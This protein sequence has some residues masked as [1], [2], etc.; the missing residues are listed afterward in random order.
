MVAI[1]KMET[2]LLEQIQ[3]PVVMAP[4]NDG[5]CRMLEI[6][7]TAGQ[8]AWEIPEDASVRVYYCK[9]DGTG[10]SYD[11]LEDGSR[12]WTAQGNVITVAL[13]PQMLSVAGN[14]AAK[15]EFQQEE[16]V[17][18]TF[19]FWI[20]VQADC[21]DGAVESEDYVNWASWTAEKLE[22]ML[23]GAKASGAFD[24]E[25]GEPGYTPVRG[26]DYWTAADLAQMAGD[27]SQEVADQLADRTQLMPEYADNQE[28]CTDT[29]KLYVLPDGYI[30]A[31][32]Y[33]EEIL[34]AYTNL[35]GEVRTDTRLNSSGVAKTLTGAVTTD[36]IPVSQGQIVRVRGFDP[37]ALVSGNYPYIC[38]YT[39]ADESAVVSS[40]IYIRGDW[41][42]TWIADGDGYRYEAF[43]YASTE[44]Q[45]ALASSI[46][47][48]RICG[49]A[50]DGA[51]II[52][53]V[54]EEIAE[55]VEGSYSWTNTGH[56]FVAA[57]YEDRIIALEE[58]VEKI[59]EAKVWTG[60]KW[61]AVGD[62]LTYD[63]YV[64]TSAYYHDHIA[65]ETGITVVNMGQGG[66]GYKRTFDT[67]EG[68]AF[69]QRI[70]NVPTDADVITIF[71]SGNDLSTTWE[72]YGLGEATDTGTD[73]I[74]GCINTTLDNLFSVFP[75][76]NVGIIT[77]TPWKAFYPSATEADGKPYRMT[78]L[79]E[80]L[81]EICRMRSIP[82]LD[83]YHCSGLRPWDKAF[84]DAV[85]TKDDV[86][87]DGELGGVHLDENGHRIIAAKIK[88]F[89]ASLI[90]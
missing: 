26:K 27:I 66:T 79:C 43:Y 31:Y 58:T 72:T 5:D 69:Y 88:A 39:A 73:T 81:V 16:S 57:D 14:V 32:Q 42:N 10:G 4:Q 45:H 37:T 29:E 22:E 84:R 36:F 44:S 76:A 7:L 18:N 1:M 48:I 33:S 50:I 78:Q 47:H 21:T 19:G 41:P 9:P 63:G 75:T 56:A 12:A 52:V 60:K 70:L 20:R 89:L 49:A 82:C 24:G 67:G 65:D 35:A 40:N 3:Y 13:V 51:E 28:A 86:E 34:P 23:E 11:T 8:E 80:K 90:S 68:Y 6:T 2:D 15:I 61:V 77:P 46:T 54:D 62:S 17:L 87:S 74:C 30:Y 85:Y 25:Q 55:V 53:T 38:C 71:G 83:L 64:T 59:T